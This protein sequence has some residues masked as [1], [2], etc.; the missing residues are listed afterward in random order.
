MDSRAVLAATAAALGLA[1]R[2]LRASASRV[3]SPAAPIAG[4]C[5]CGAL[6][7][8]LSASAKSTCEQQPTPLALCLTPAHRPRWPGVAQ[9]TATA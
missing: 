1:A 4:G 3:A 6:R 2:S 9:T 5:Q 7:Y 8:A